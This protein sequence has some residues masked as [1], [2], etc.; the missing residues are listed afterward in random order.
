MSC[1]HTVEFKTPCVTTV[2]FKL[3]ILQSWKR[4]AIRPAIDTMLSSVLLAFEIWLRH[5][6]PHITICYTR[7]N[8]YIFPYCGH[9]AICGRFHFIIIICISVIAKISHHEFLLQLFIHIGATHFQLKR[10]RFR[11]SHRTSTERKGSFS[12]RDHALQA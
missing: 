3:N 4:I 9:L 6:H 1:N 5:T 12:P 7:I 11:T 10:I 2:G 8:I